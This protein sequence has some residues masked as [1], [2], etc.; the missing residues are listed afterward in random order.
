MKTI[1]DVTQVEAL[2]QDFQTASGRVGKLGREVLAEQAGELHDLQV[3]RVRAT[4]A[5]TGDLE[6]HLII[7]MRG[8]G[9]STT[10]SAW[11]GSDGNERNAH[12]FFLENGTARMP[13]QPWNEPAA[14]HA[15]RTWPVRAEKLMQEV[16]DAI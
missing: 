5:P 3:A 1:V 2:S 12:G 14:A 7:S 15:E 13:A 9:R 8:D 6:S 10:L 11:V 16:T 4:K